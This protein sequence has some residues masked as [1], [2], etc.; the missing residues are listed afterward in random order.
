[1]F[2]LTELRDPS[3]RRR[4]WRARQGHDAH[5]RVLR[6]ALTEMMVAWET[7][8]RDGT[9]PMGDRYSLEEDTACWLFGVGG[10]SE[11]MGGVENNFW[12]LQIVAMIGVSD[13]EKNYT[14]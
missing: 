3:G 4:G 6:P 5:S 10:V 12:R 14:K 11:G 8:H 13:S 7:G 2:T 1:M 9:G